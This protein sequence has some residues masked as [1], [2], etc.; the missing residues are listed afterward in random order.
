MGSRYGIDN[1]ILLFFWNSI[2]AL[3]AMAF[4]YTVAV[5][6]LHRIGLPPRVVRKIF[7]GKASGN[8]TGKIFRMP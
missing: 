4:T 3:I 8:G 1:G 7:I 5:F 6:D 2:D